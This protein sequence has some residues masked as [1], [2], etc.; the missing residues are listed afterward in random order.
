MLIVALILL[1]DKEEEKEEALLVNHTK[2]D[3]VKRRS[4]HQEH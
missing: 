4:H 1:R 3:A 2:Y